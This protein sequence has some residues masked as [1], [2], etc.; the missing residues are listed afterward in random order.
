[1]QVSEERNS[2]I[3]D[4]MTFGFSTALLLSALAGA[5]YTGTFSTLLQDFARILT[6]PGPLVTDYFLIGSMP[7]AFLN[8]S[9]C[10]YMM[11]YCMAFLPGPSHVNTLA[12]YFLVIAHAFYGL[13]LLNM[14]PC[15][16]AP[17]LYLWLK[18]LD[19]NENLHVCMFATCFSPFVSEFLFR[20]T[21]GDSYVPGEVHLTLKG[22]LL[23]L[24]FMLFL[25][26]RGIP[27]RKPDLRSR[28]EAGGEAPRGKA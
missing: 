3:I 14:L 28:G 9:L 4:G 7:E 23:T 6:S 11:W 24:G 21:L 20:Y 27:G 16:A 1:M 22:I 19:Y 13:N 10:G 15:F 12:G 25:A 26:F 5:A 18:D 2:R 8:A 17:F